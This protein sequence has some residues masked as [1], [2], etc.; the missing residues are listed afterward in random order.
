VAVATLSLACRPRLSTLDRWNLWQRLTRYRTWTGPDDEA[1]DGTNDATERATGWWVAER[2][3]PMRRMHA[4]TVGWPR[5]PPD[6]V[7]DHRR[8]AI[9]ASH[10]K[11]LN[12]DGT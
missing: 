7:E 3:C 11:T 12:G 2:N 10:P 8:A 4:V 1:L 5:Q 6:C 9:F